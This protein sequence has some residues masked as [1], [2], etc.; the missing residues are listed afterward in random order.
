MN[1]PFSASDAAELTRDAPDKP[2]RP[3][4]MARLKLPLMIGGVAL[5]L[6]GAGYFWLTSGRHES[7]D[8]AYIEAAGVDISSN[9]AGRVVEIDVKENQRVRAGQILFRLDPAP[10]DLAVRQD[11]AKVDEARQ[12]IDTA[13]AAYRQRQVDVKNALDAAAYAERER[14]REQQL[15]GAGAVSKSDFDQADRAAN[16]ARLQVQDAQQQLAAALAALGGRPDLP[17]DK[18]SEV[19]D[20]LAQ[21]GKAQLEKSWTV[22][23]A[24]QDGRVTKVEQLQVG[25]YINASA[26]VFHLITGEPWISAKFKENQLTHMR[27]G[28]PVQVSVD[29]YRDHACEGRIQSI[30]PASDQTFS[31]LPP[32][33][34]TGN[35]VKVVQRLPVRITFACRPEFDPAAGLSAIVNVDTGWSRRL[36]AGR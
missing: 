12:E 19:E 3:N 16:N 23:V 18:H 21:L 25:D 24:P 13:Q 11:A 32:Q 5:V 15:L 2:D 28:Q 9:I 6:A 22:I 7:T 29:A 30:A 35:W 26:P 36:F 10:H 20:S 14:G 34:D 8:D 27:V 4:L 31:A 17:T 33:N 1:A